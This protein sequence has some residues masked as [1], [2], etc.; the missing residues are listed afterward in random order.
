MR[1]MRLMPIYRKPNTSRPAKGHKTFPYLLGALRV[2]RPDQVCCADITYLP[3]RHAVALDPDRA[4]ARAKSDAA[5]S[6]RIDGAW[7]GNRKL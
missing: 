1:L 7:A 5:L 2:D 6:L 3:L 4:S